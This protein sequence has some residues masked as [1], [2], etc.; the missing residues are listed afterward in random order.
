MAND[1]VP[2][3]RKRINHGRE[4]RG[5]NISRSEI[6]SLLERGLDVTKI[7]RG[8]RRKQKKLKQYG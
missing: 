4:S 5:V 2:R 8:K 1:H 6:S 3:G 7:F